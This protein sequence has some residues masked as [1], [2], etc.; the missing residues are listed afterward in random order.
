MKLENQVCTLQQAKRLQ[1]LG[2]SQESHFQWK[3]NEIQ[4]VVS[5]SKFCYQII[6]HLPGLNEYWAAYTVAELGVMLGLDCTGS[7]LTKSFPENRVTE[8]ND[9]IDINENTDQSE[10]CFRADLLIFCIES[11]FISVALVN[12]RLSS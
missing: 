11:K 7:L 5:E 2:V 1:E 10:A 8:I 9:W 12:E 4:S 3:V 6:T